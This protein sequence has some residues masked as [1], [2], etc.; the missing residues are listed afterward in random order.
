MA[1]RHV[2]T[3]PAATG[4]SER[5]YGHSSG[6]RNTKKSEQD[7]KEFQGGQ[8]RDAT[9]SAPAPKRDKNTGRH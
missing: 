9:P 6:D 8:Q 2:D 3:D 4:K 5:E 1:R 7:W